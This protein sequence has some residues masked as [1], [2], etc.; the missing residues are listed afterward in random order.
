MDEL[1]FIG[2]GGGRIVT[3]TQIRS[4]SGMWVCLDGTRV[5]LD[6]GPGALA[7][8]FR[9]R[10]PLDPTTLD[11][12]VL[13]H[14]HLDHAGDVNAMIEAMTEGGVR[15]RGALFAP[16]DAYE[17]DPVILQYVRKYLSN[18]QVLEEGESFKIGPVQ[19]E[20]ACRMQHPVQ[21]YGLRFVGSQRTV[22]IVACTGYFPELASHYLKSDV[23]IINVVSKE[24]RDPVHLSLPDARE[25]I[26]RVKPRLAILTHFGLTM[27]RAKPRELAE[28][29]TEET[30]VTVLAARDH[31]RLK[32]EGDM[33]G[34]E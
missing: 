8:C 16:V 20:V 19:L 21:T 2:T 15:R 9:T 25:L 17:K 10:P 33:V 32:L 1:I 22:G 7:H 6:P 24:P 11:A 27:I 12:I 29:L 23:L 30:G 14:K 28:R 26:L 18:C 31:Q 3:A 13:T 4:T 34:E 5:A